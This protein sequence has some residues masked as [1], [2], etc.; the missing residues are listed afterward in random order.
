MDKPPVDARTIRMAKH[1]VTIRE[2]A[3]AA[4]LTL[5]RGRYVRRYG[6][7]WDWP[8]IIRETADAK[9]DKAATPSLAAQR[10]TA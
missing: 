6:G 2:V 9:A 3:V 7:P 5:K 10:G 4:D 8:Q 1:R